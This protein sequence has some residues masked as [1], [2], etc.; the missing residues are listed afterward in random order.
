M[1]KRL[2]GFLFV[3]F[4]FSLITSCGFPGSSD[5]E[6]S[7]SSQSVNAPSSISGKTLNCTQLNNK[8]STTSF[9]FSWSSIDISHKLPTMTHTI[10]TPSYSYSK[11]GDSANLIIKY[12]AKSSWGSSRNGD[13][14]T[15]VYTCD[16]KLTFTSSTSGYMSGT[17]KTLTNST[18]SK[19]ETDNYSIS[20]AEFSLL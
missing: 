6:D 14:F 16:L 7:N 18:I 10:G 17:I 20:Y 1:Y 13:S 2:F 12:T 11:N 9:D 3:I 4:T 5:E 15:I 19:N 8:C